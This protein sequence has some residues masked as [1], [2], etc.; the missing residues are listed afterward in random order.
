MPDD[1]FHKSALAEFARAKAPEFIA[2]F[3]RPKGRCFY[4]KIICETRSKKLALVALLLAATCIQLG[5]R[6]QREPAGIVTVLIESSP[7][8]LDPR[9]G[10]DAQ[11]ERI[12]SL[13]FDSLVRKDE[14]FNPT[15]WLALRWENSDALTYIFHL[16]DGVHFHDG[17]VLTSADV[18]YT[19]DTILQGRV[20]SV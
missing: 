5:C 12:D 6:Q 13:I 15:P 20:I 11:S 17:R 4:P 18:K 16:R 3:H 19:L 9:I 10:V 7:T 2:R 14:H 1:A 8:N